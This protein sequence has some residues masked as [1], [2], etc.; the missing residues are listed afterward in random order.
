MLLRMDPGESLLRHRFRSV[1]DD[2]KGLDTHYQ[3]SFYPGSPRFWTASG[4]LTVTGTVLDNDLYTVGIER[5]RINW[6][7]GR[8]LRFRVFH[9]GHTQAAVPVKLL[10]EEFGNA[11]DDD[12]LG[13]RPASIPYGANTITPVVYTEANDGSDGDAI[14]TVRLLP[15]DGYVVDPDNDIAA[16]IVKDKDPLPVIR[17]ESDR[18]DIEESAGTGGEIWVE[19]VSALP[20][21][22]EV[23]VAWEITGPAAAKDGQ[24]FTASTGRLRFAPGETRKAIPVEIL[25]DNLA[26]ADEQF[27]VDIRH[28]LNAVLQDG[29]TELRAVLEIQDD[30][31]YITMSEPLDTVVEGTDVEFTFNRTGSTAEEL[32][33]WVRVIQSSPKNVT[34]QEEVVFAA[35]E[36]TATL[37][38]PT[39][40]DNV[41][42]GLYT[43]RAGM[44]YPPIIGKPQTYWRDG[45]LSHT[46]EVRDN[47]LPRVN[48]EVEDGRVF[49]G[50]PV[51][52][53]LIRADGEDEALT[54]PLDIEA[55]ASYVSATVP[56]ELTIGAGQKRLEYTI[57][58][59][60]DAVEEDNAQLTVTIEDGEDYRP[61]YP[62]SFTFSIF[63]NDG[64]LPGVR[65]RATEDWVDEGEDVVFRVI[66]SG[67]T[68]EALDARLRLYRLR[69]RVTA[70]E[71]SDPTLGV[72]TPVYLVPLD[73]EEITVN[74]P[75]GQH[76][77]S[78]TRSTTDD[79]VNHG[80]ST[81]HAFVL[82]G[83][84]DP[85]TAFY[86][87][88]D[89]VWVQDD[90]RP[91]VTIGKRPHD[92][93]LR[94]P[95][96][97]LPRSVPG[98][99]PHHRAG[100][101]DPDRGLVNPPH[102]QRQEPADHPMAGAQD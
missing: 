26:E 57:Q 73:H 84:D 38:V 90:D 66:R 25:Q 1:D 24:D 68:T 21:P 48:L 63:D 40:D 67:D 61:G 27:V 75:V 81:Y 2:Y 50:N 30:E 28:P 47:D 72:T 58:T 54:V 5:I 59:V 80:N 34:T 46:V 70:A 18:V 99:R 37:T 101:A 52:F 93:V 23:S 43:V 92:G 36:A 76:T 100:R 20:V 44:L 102:R 51:T 16:M 9:D 56:T 31:P 11:V 88:T 55:P 79:S 33:I 74:F 64:D 12:L 60:D 71:L 95:G 97:A 53:T 4:D 6:D 14:F 82:A 19:L 77:V 13:E 7:E 49:E 45:T 69:S 3:A 86:E 35:G 98:Q 96:S 87:H 42:R 78:V 94:V 10:I 22:R 32:T 91:V 89:S 62:N 8:P 29:Q 39:D 65:V 85:Y 17:F 41:R 15:G 83:Q